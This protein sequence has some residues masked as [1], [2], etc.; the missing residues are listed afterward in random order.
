MVGNVRG[1]MELNSY[2]V[3][4]KLSGPLGKYPGVRDEETVVYR[5]RAHSVTDAVDFSRLGLQQT[6][7]LYGNMELLAVVPTPAVA[8]AGNSITNEQAMIWGC[9]SI[10]RKPDP[11]C[12]VEPPAPDLPSN[13]AIDSLMLTLEFADRTVCFPDRNQVAERRGIVRRWHRAHSGRSDAA[14][15]ALADRIRDL[16]AHAKLGYENV[17]NTSDQCRIVTIIKDWLVSD[18]R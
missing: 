14:V 10:D 9:G 4:W 2:S 7:S 15:C 6:H 5:T 16:V 3:T 17:L 12:P 18:L 1:D 8:M 13:A 11:G